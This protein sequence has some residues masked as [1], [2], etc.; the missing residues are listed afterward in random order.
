MN[1]GI[2]PPPIRM[3]SASQVSPCHADSRKTAAAPTKPF[4]RVGKMHVPSAG[5][6]KEDALLAISVAIVVANANGR[7]VGYDSPVA[8]RRSKKRSG[9][10]GSGGH[11]TMA[12]V[13]RR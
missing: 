3:L 12:S 9:L 5:P 6:A 1:D 7:R 2:L 13:L 10:D 4:H 8:S 11:H